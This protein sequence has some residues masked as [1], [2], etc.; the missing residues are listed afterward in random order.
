M[1]SISVVLDTNVL[2]SALIFSRGRLAWL[3]EAWCQGVVIPLICKETTIELIQVL[4]YPKFK[5]TTSEQEDL[6]ADIL[7]YC[8]IFE[9]PVELPD[10][11]QC[12]DPDDQVFLSLA[13]VAN[14]NYLVSGDSDILVLK[15]NFVVSIVR[16]SEL[17]EHLTLEN[18]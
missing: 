16:P 10:L 7:P 11:A 1:K 15:D 18:L 13:Y 14:V 17:R 2:V 6:L 12:R 5:L 3:R 9:L 4:A 8:E